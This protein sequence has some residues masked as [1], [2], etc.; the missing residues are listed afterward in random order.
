MTLGAEAAGEARDALRAAMRARRVALSPEAQRE[1]AEA[2]AVRL[3]QAFPGAET[4]GVYAATQGELSLE[5]FIRACPPS[6][7]FA[8]PRTTRAGEMELAVAD[9]DTLTPGKYG[10]LTAKNAPVLAPRALDVMLI[11]GTAF[12]RDGG[13]LGM[14]G[15]YYD[16]YLAQ[17]RPDCL[18]VGVGYQWQIVETLPLL[19]HDITMTHLVSDKEYTPC[20]PP[21]SESERSLP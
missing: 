16:R 15:G 6:L 17:V 7:R 4:I 3:S 13:R 14:G 1:A 20:T 19:P 18:R 21:R 10:I 5:P 2:L 11:P 9:I 12:S 8:W